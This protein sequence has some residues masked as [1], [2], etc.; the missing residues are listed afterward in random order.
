M[1]NLVFLGIQAD[2]LFAMCLCRIIRDDTDTPIDEKYDLYDGY[3]ERYVKATLYIS[4]LKKSIDDESLEKLREH[5]VV[6][7]YLDVIHL[8][9]SGYNIWES[10][11][12][13]VCEFRD[14]F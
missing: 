8:I 9:G 7:Y 6:K 13:R 11:D 10:D 12:V 2:Q 5:F 14:I 4:W 1:N 3:H